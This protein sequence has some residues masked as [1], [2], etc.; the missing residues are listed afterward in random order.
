MATGPV[1]QMVLFQIRRNG[2]WEV[3]VELIFLRIANK[4]IN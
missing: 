4:A 3:V 1:N 2:S